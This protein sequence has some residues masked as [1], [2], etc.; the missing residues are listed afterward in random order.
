MIKGD[1]EKGLSGL[2]QAE[3]FIYA[4]G[5]KQSTLSPKRRTLHHCYVYMGIMA[6]TTSMTSSPTTDLTEPRSRILEDPIPTDFRIRLEVT[7]SENILDK[8]KDPSIAIPGRWSMTLFPKM[9]GIAESFLMLLSQVIRLA[10]ERDL[11][12][13]HDERLGILHL[14]DFWIRAKALEKGIRLLCH[15]V[16]LDTPPQTRRE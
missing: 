5:F 4:H 6:E 13:L 2:I 8:E 15:F 7:F 10:N 3:K 12:I 16:L 14:K 1:S 9:Y 11:S